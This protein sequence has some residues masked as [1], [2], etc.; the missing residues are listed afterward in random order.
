MNCERLSEAP[1]RDDA[2]NERDG[3]DIWGR[4][5]S[6]SGFHLE[7]AAMVRICCIEKQEHCE[8]DLNCYAPVSWYGGGVV[9][10]MNFVERGSC[11]SG[12]TVS[13]AWILCMAYYMYGIC[14]I[15]CTCW[16][17]SPCFCSAT[18]NYAWSVIHNTL[19]PRSR[20]Q[21][22]EQAIDPHS[23]CMFKQQGSRVGSL[24]PPSTSTIY[25]RPVPSLRLF[26]NQSP[27]AKLFRC[28][29][30]IVSPYIRQRHPTQPVSRYAQVANAQ[31]EAYSWSPEGPPH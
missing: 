17:P 24:G 12:C 7:M 23:T 26:Q 21:S 8:T 5:R 3:D 9:A 2:P 16:Y 14:K 30:N 1:A 11:A 4:S 25:S 19:A 22:V 28:A 10:S 31:N 15:H 6:G 20:N 13:G 27:I 29:D 18:T